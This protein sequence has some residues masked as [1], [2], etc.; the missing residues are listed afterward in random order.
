[1]I[2]FKQFLSEPGYMGWVGCMGNRK[3]APKLLSGRSFLKREIIIFLMI[4]I[5]IIK[6]S[7][8][9]FSLV[10]CIFLF[11]DRD[12]QVVGIFQCRFFF[13]L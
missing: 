10:L 4:L 11:I 13:H 12:Q 8:I 9:C 3:T 1:M 7:G 2:R 5:Y 6:F